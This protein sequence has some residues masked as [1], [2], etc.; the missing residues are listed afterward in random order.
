[1]ALCGF[2]PKVTLEFTSWTNHTIEH[3]VE[4]DWFANGV[5]GVGVLDLM[6]TNNRTKLLAGVIVDLKAGQ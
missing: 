4:L 3:E 1:M 6:F 5:I 2:G